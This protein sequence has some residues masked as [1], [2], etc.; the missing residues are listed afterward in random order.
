MYEPEEATWIE[1][2]LSVVEASKRLRDC[3][4]LETVEKRIDGTFHYYEQHRCLNCPGCDLHLALVS[5]SAF[6]L[7]ELKGK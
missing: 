7:T 1:A 6:G 2:L 4:N 5:L 3:R